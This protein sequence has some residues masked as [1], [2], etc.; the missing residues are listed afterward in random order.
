MPHFNGAVWFT[1][2]DLL[3][4]C[5]ICMHQHSTSG[6]RIR[7]IRIRSLPYYGQAAWQSRL[8]RTLV[9]EQPHQASNSTATTRGAREAKQPGRCLPTTNETFR[10]SVHPNRSQLQ[11][12]QLPTPR[13]SLSQHI[14][15]VTELF[16]SASNRE[17]SPSHRIFFSGRTLAQNFFFTPQT[18][19]M[20]REVHRLVILF[21]LQLSMF[22]AFETLST[23]HGNLFL[24][25]WHQLCCL[26]LAMQ[27]CQQLCVSR[28]R[29]VW[30]HDRGLYQPG[31]FNQNLLGSFNAREFKG[32]MRMNVSIFV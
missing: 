23:Q 29:S 4:R 2:L 25:Q 3:E 31:F 22:M 10:I 32:R 24:W 11:R 26:V 5:G 6:I 1:P 27:G 21:F 8:G 9:W 19:S 7:K 13:A 17:L 14:D 12:D 18:P 20:D 28:L 16:L 15:V 30:A